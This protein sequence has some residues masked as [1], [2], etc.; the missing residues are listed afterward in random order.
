MKNNLMVLFA[1]LL[2]SSGVAASELQP[3]E[4]P[5]TQVMPIR[6]SATGRQ[7]ELVI[8]LPEGYSEKEDVIRPVIYFTDADWHIEILGASAEYLVED[9]ILVGISWQKDIRKELVEEVGPHVSRFQ[10][11]TV[12]PYSNPKIQEKYQMGQASNHLKF[13]RNDVIKTIENT[14]RTD[15]DRRTYFGYSLGGLFGAYILMVQ[16]DTFKNYILGSPGLERDMPYFS[17]LAS[18][19]A[20]K[21]KTF[22]ANVFISR[23]SSEEELAEL[24]NEFITLL[25]S[26]NDESLFLDYE[27]IEGSHQTAF[28]L[29]GVRSVTWLSGLGSEQILQTE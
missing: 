9:A 19:E 3:Y 17:E 7:Y 15:P 21:R 24:I 12:R 22:N 18:E 8:K 11:F 23:G 2:L 26:R 29:T 5:R 14:Y 25:N 16:P 1:L 28:P 13:I 10:D 6:D 4:S 27:V 20:I